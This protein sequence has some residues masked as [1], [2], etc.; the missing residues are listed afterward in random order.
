MPL[1]VVRMP[2][3]ADADAPVERAVPTVAVVIAAHNEESC[4][5]STLRAALSQDYPVSMVLVV[6]DNCTDATVSIA[7]SIP[8]VTVVET[9]GNRHKKP[10]ALNLAWSLFKD[11]IEYFACLDADTII[12]TDAVRLWVE[13]MLVEPATGG[14]SARF[15][16]Q[17]KP[18]NT[19][20]ENLLARLQKAE[21]AQWTDTALGRGGRTTVLAGTACMVSVAALDAVNAMR[22]AEGV[23][24]GPWSYSSDVEDFELTYRMRQ[25]GYD[26]KV[27]YTVRAYTDAM[28]SLKTLWA[29]RMKWQGG[30]VD[31]LLRIG[32]NRLTWRDWGQQ[33]LGLM[34]AMVRISW[35]AMTLV[36]CAIGTLNV[37]FLWLLIPLLFI[38][39]DVKKS[40]RV[41][42]RDWKDVLLAAL[43]LPQ[44]LFAWVRAGWF[45]KSW[46]ECLVQRITGK[47]KDRW[48]AQISAEATLIS[49]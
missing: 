13:Q 41:P 30:T 4:I 20:W 11:D 3:S 22:L 24:D 18:E 48:A 26:A 46:A 14:I 7:N 33:A 44:E 43:L 16:M 36:Y 31:D 29:Q 42:H 9:V 28:V 39:N 27:S 35:I 23:D 34:A 40:M 1:A 45:L 47:T 5:E 21:F 37:N 38:A 12:T 19:A 25:L 2:Q 15:T 17:P 10:G 8:G 49:L 32:I 6:A